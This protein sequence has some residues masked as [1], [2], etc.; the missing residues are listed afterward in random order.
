MSSKS[1]ICADFLVGLFFQKTNEIPKQIMCQQVYG[2][3]SLLTHTYQL[4]DKIP[5]SSYISNIS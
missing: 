1:L 3:L 4:Y 2:Q 5:E